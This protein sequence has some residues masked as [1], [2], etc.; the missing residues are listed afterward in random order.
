MG[1]AEIMSALDLRDQKHFRQDYQQA[2]LALGLIEM[3]VP[4]KPNSR[5]Q[6]YRLSAAGSAHL[7]R[8]NDGAT[9]SGVTPEVTPGVTPEVTPEVL[10]L[11]AVLKGEM[12]RAEI[13]SALDLRDQKHFRQIYQQA[14]LALGLIEMTVPDKPNSR[15][16]KYRLSAAG[17]A[18]LARPNDGATV[19]AVTP[20]VTPSKPPATRPPRS[21]KA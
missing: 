12:G 16:Q 3:T 10:R 19:A 18:H 8:P 9:T 20:E 14:A 15:L 6:K 1:R 2:A 5:H 11:L 4:D 13:M 21:G 7:A 17:R